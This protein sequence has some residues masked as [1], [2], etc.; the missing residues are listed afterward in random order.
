MVEVFDLGA[1][2]RSSDALDRALRMPEV[3]GE[4]AAA[5][6]L[7][8]DHML[9]ATSDETL[10]DDAND[11]AI[12]ASSVVIVDLAGRQVKSRSPTAEPLGSLM[13]VDDEVAVSFFEHPKLFS[14]RTGAVLKRW[15]T[16]KSGNQVSSI[17]WNDVLDPPIAI[18]V[19]NRRFAVA[20]A[21][22]VAVVELPQP[23]EYEGA[24]SQ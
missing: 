20:D 24:A 18:D 16:V 11:E 19:P 17:I 12:G 3:N 22:S 10:D 1:A 15:R 8:T 14:L 7:R 2:I 13:P 21:S 9:I 23:E 4:V 5:E 6:V